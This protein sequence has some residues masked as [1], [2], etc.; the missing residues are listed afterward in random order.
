[1]ALIA[2]T[3]TAIIMVLATP[4]S[5]A[6][7]VVMGAASID[8]T[9]AMAALRP[10]NVDGMPRFSRMMDRSGKPRPMAM[11]TAL[12]AAMAAIS[13]GQWI[14]STWPLASVVGWGIHFSLQS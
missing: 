10:I 14:R 2:A 8:A 4:K 7:L 11:P 9:P 6:S 5:W 1:M 12:M 3:T 13:D